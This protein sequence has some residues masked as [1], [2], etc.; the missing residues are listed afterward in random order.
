MHGFNHL[1][2]RFQIKCLLFMMRKWINHLTQINNGWI[3]LWVA[4][5]FIPSMQEFMVKV[6]IN[7]KF[8]AGRPRRWSE[9][10][11]V[12]FMKIQFNMDHWNTQLDFH[13]D[14]V[15]LFCFEIQSD[16]MAIFNRTT[17]YII[18]SRIP[19][20]FRFFCYAEIHLQISHPEY[21]SFRVDRLENLV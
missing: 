21:L 2:I 8:N 16:K 5:C 7:I 15:R 13:C 4:F 20:R 17:P 14:S 6:I 12:Y 10:K 18:S 11:N 1:Y 3:M 19:I 9:S